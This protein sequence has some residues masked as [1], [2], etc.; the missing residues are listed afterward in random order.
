VFELVK[1]AGGYTPTTL[2]NFDGSNGASPYGSLIA[3]AAGDL[4]G[5]TA[6]VG[7]ASPGTVFELVKSAGGYT[8]ATLFSFNGANGAQPYSS[9]LIDAAGDLFGVTLHGGTSGDGTVF[10]LANTASGYTLNT[11]VNFNGANGADP[12][13]SLTVDAA[14]DL[15]GTTYQG[16]SFGDGTVFEVTD[17]GYVV[18]NPPVMTDVVKGPDTLSGTA[19]ANSTVQIFDGSQLFGT[20][21]ADASGNWS[22]QGNVRGN[23]IA[24]FTETSTDAAGNTFSS[25]GETLF[26][27]RANVTLTGG[28]GADVLIAGQNDTLTGGGGRDTF[29]FNPHFGKDV[30]TDFNPAL[31]VLNIS[32]TLFSNVSDLL[33]HS[34]DAKGNAVIHADAADTI[35][36]IGVSVADLAA[37]PTDIH[38]F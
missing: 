37:N 21:I 1:T 13:G 18:A 27:Q 12:V 16:G 9:L 4:F 31:D 14:G 34:T 15:F 11:L 6:G 28:S 26:A 22:L 33:A 3:D 23:A 7:S 20:A 29:V 2:L 8:L 5:T 17:S 24:H 35:T 32:S 25:T 36:L 30:I 38:F 19:E 10:E